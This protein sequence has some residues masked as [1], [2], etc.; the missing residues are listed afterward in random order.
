MVK[1]DTHWRRSPKHR[2]ATKNATSTEAARDDPEPKQTK[3]STANNAGHHPEENCHRPLCAH[4][5]LFALVTDCQAKNYL[6]DS[7]C[8]LAHF[9]DCQAPEAH[10][11]RQGQAP[12]TQSY[13][14]T[15][16]KHSSGMARSGI[17]ENFTAC[18]SNS[19]S[20][21]WLNIHLVFYP[22]GAVPRK[23]NAKPPPILTVSR[24]SLWTATPGAP[25]TLPAQ[26]ERTRKTSSSR[27]TPQK[28]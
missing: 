16:Q 9:R 12:L 7:V 5:Y 6:Q 22:E 11:A 2:H 20:E 23:G 3:L 27:T 4:W 25:W 15:P 10:R 1:L 24:H 18:M 28:S 17:V 14:R 8:S 21:I 26:R 19:L 13:L